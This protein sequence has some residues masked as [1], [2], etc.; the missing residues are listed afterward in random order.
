M[1]QTTGQ[2]TELTKFHGEF[3]YWLRDG[4][5]ISTYIPIHDRMYG[6]VRVLDVLTELVENVKDDPAERNQLSPR[7]HCGVGQACERLLKACDTRYPTFDAQHAASHAGHSPNPIMG[8]SLRFEPVETIPGARSCPVPRPASPAAP[9]D[10]PKGRRIVPANP[11]VEE[12]HPPHDSGWP[13]DHDP[14]KGR[15]ISSSVPDPGWPNKP[16]R[17]HLPPNKPRGAPRSGMQGARLVPL[18]RRR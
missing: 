6:V 14:N 13:K 5:K 12:F 18:V 3:T 9:A 11:P 4:F 2:T 16:R 8:I 17:L 15:G 1:G 10:P 7:G